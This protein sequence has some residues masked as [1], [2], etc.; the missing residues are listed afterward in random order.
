MTSIYATLY[1][2]E[3]TTLLQELA[4][5]RL[6]T[7]SPRTSALIEMRLERIE[8]LERCRE[9]ADEMASAIDDA[10]IEAA[11]VIEIASPSQQMEEIAAELSATQPALRWRVDG[12]MLIGNSLGAWSV[13]VWR[14]GRG[15][16]GKVVGYWWDDADGEHHGQMTAA[17]GNAQTTAMLL[18]TSMAARTEQVAA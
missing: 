17:A 6:H 5:L 18:I 14:V 11:E 15:W 1:T 13:L 9:L 2:D 8:E 16:Q 4:V 3:L 12:L 7:P 10:A